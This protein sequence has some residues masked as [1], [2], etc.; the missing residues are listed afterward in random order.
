MMHSTLIILESIFEHNSAEIGG[1]YFVTLAPSQSWNVPL[2]II[3]LK[4]EEQSL[5]TTAQCK[6]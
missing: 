5:L 4:R 6:S 2:I 3:V 1:A